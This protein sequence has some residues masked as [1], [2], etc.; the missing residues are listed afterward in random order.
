MTKGAVKGMVLDA[1]FNGTFNPSELRIVGSE[2][3][4]QSCRNMERLLSLL[5]IQLSGEDYAMVEELTDELQNACEEE[6]RQH[7]EYG[8]AAGLLLMREAQEFIQMHTEK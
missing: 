7:F 8:F 6:C 2:R 4:T 3:F 1:I 5:S